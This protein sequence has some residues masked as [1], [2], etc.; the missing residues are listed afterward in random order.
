MKPPLTPKRKMA[1]RASGLVNTFR[2]NGVLQGGMEAQ[3]PFPMPCPMHLSIW[4]FLSYL[5]SKMFLSVVSSSKLIEPKQRVL[6]TSRLHLA[7]QKHGLAIGIWSGGQ[8]YGAEPLTSRIWC[9]LWGNCVRI[10]INYRTP[11]W[12]PR[13]AFLLI[14]VCVCGWSWN[15]PCN[16]VHS[17]Y[18]H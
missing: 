9:C 18:H 15:S 2:E 10:E 8:C 4:L 17:S 1:W 6:G 7:G 16:W 13:L 14:V 12:C 11:S 3:S 5:I